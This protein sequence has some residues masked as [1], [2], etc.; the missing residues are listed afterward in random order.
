MRPPQAN[1]RGKLPHLIPESLIY[2][3]PTQMESKVG[4][5]GQ[6]ITCEANYFRL[7]KH[8]NWNIYHYRVDFM[9]DVM[10]ART[11]RRL[12]ATQRPMLGGYLFDG[13]QLFITRALEEESV[14][15]VIPIEENQQEATYT[16]TF[17][18]TR[19]VA[20]TENQSLQILNLILRRAMDGLHLETIGR[21]KFDAD[22]AVSV[23]VLFQSCSFVCIIRKNSICFT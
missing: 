14:T 5:T 10:D 18:L 11:R 1:V 21:N 4:I 20:M 15:R 7:D 9:P 22:A 2:T 3:R 6:K 12:I 13:A 19:M 17:R 8:P 23:F 16:V